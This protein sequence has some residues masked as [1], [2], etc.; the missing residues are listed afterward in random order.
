MPQRAL[1]LC[2]K[3]PALAEPGTRYC[4]RHRDA[5]RQAD[6]ERRAA[7]PLRQE[8]NRNSKAW[9]QTRALTL[10]Y[11]PQCAQIS[12]DGVRCVQL[13]TDAHHV[14]RA[15]DWVAQGGDY[16]DQ[17]NLVGLCHEHHTQHTQAEIHGR[18]VPGS[19]APPDNEWSPVI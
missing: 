10:Y 5:Q 11:Y 15:V 1:R 9:R 3:C 19:F 2:S 8:F 6:R 14:V 7:N 4:P 17:S 13:S 16:M 18:E 12:E